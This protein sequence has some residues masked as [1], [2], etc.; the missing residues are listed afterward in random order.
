[1]QVPELTD[2][3]VVELAR[4]GGVA[5]IPGLRSQR[6][7]AL[8]AQL[9]RNRR[10]SACATSWSRPFRAASRRDRPR[11]PAAA[12]SAISASRLATRPTAKPERL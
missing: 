3:A 9:G 11:H 6:R 10:S 12:T 2:D 7:F 5:F 4:E 8:P 1:M